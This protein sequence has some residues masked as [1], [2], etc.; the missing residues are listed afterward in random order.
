MKL[1]LLSKHI[2][3]N[4]MNLYIYS[5]RQKQ[6]KLITNG[7]ALLT[8][9]MLLIFT[10]VI[11]S[12]AAKEGKLGSYMKTDLVALPLSIF[13]VISFCLLLSF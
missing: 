2:L 6:L 3:I 11:F 9:Y 13:L 8:H 12:L 4:K 10:K 5:E 7:K 1:S